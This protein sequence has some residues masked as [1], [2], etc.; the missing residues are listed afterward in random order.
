MRESWS[1]SHQPRFGRSDALE[2]LAPSSAATCHYSPATT[3]RGNHQPLLVYSR[4]P[5]IAAK[6]TTLLSCIPRLICNNRLCCTLAI[7][8]HLLRSN[9]SQEACLDQEAICCLASLLLVSL[10]TKQLTSL[11]LQ[12]CAYALLTFSTLSFLLSPPLSFSLT[13]LLL[14]VRQPTAYDYTFLANVK[15]LLCNATGSLATANIKRLPFAD[16][17]EPWIS[18]LIRILTSSWAF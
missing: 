11:Q 16:F 7:A 15:T 13:N 1:S 14:V 9:A 3:C 8:H 2:A 12:S 17:C 6:Y 10:T 4:L 5:F 18:M